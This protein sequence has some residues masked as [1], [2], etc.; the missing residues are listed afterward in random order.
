MWQRAQE[1]LGN[2]A[3]DAL[4]ALTTEWF[5]R[6]PAGL[7]VTEQGSVLPKASAALATSA[8]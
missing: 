4:F 7:V 3:Q 5:I 8:L 2:L 1:Q 6:T